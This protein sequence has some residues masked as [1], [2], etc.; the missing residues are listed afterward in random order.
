MASVTAPRYFRVMFDA[1]NLLCLPAPSAW[2][3][4]TLLLTGFLEFVQPLVM[5]WFIVTKNTM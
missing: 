5:R 3:A 1:A 2:E 4:A